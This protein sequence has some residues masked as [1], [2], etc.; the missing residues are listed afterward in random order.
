MKQFLP[1]EN[2][3]SINAYDNT[4]W[5]T[6]LVLNEL[7]QA[8][9]AEKPNSW[10]FYSSDHG[11]HVTGKGGAFHGDFQDEVTHNSF[12]VFPPA[13]YYEAVVGKVDAPLSQADIFAT[14]LE[15]MQVEPVTPIDGLSLLGDIP[16][17]RMRIVTAFMK[18]LHNDPRAALVFPDR[19]IW[20][21]D[22]ERSNVRLADGES[23]I[24]YRQM[25]KQYRQ[26]FDRRINAGKT[27]E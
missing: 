4:V 18:T 17:D 9:R 1:E 27:S 11:E 26:M 7:F 20:E 14:L 3:N 22:F 19:R 5:Y 25:D 15:L 8:V 23:V 16:E 21:V 6:D 2:P 24:P 12:L 10:I 13:S